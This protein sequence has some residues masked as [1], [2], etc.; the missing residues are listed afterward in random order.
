MKNLKEIK[1]IILNH[2]TELKEKF[3]IKEIGIFGSYARG[4]ENKF[5]DIDILVEFEEG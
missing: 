1:K 4:E 3:G 5:S 2:L